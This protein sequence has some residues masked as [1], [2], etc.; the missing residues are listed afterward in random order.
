MDFKFFNKNRHDYDAILVVVD[1]LGKRSF[2]L[3]TY[4]TCIAADLA[5]LYYAFPW[6]I[7]WNPRNDYFRPRSPVC[8]RIFEKTVKA[9][10]NHA[11]TINSRTC[12]NGW[13]NGNR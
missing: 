13:A 4:K 6:R 10:W 2:F 12:R 7:F 1:R 5:E 8:C 3:P 9:H 11:I